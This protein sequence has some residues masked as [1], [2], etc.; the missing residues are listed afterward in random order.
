MSQ[1]YKKRKNKLK[2]TSNSYDRKKLFEIWHA[3]RLGSR[4]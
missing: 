2:M 3:K 4:W 1:K